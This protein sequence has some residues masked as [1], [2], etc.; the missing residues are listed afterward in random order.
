MYISYLIN[1]VCLD[2]AY[3]IDSMK[4]C[5]NNWNISSEQGLFLKSPSEHFGKKYLLKKHTK[6]EQGFK[7]KSIW[8]VWKLHYRW[9]LACVL[10]IRMK[11]L[12]YIIT[13]DTVFWRLLQNLIGYS[14]LTIITKLLWVLFCD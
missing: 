9:T 6:L 3:F 4:F 8:T 13:L 14:F 5:D 10:I 1:I 7:Q 12:C 2:W 11:S